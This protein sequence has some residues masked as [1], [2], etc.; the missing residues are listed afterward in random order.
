MGFFELEFEDLV[1][2]IGMDLY[3]TDALSPLLIKNTRTT[4]LIWD[5]YYR[6]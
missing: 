1:D 4:V 2:R 6:W 5:L 3:H